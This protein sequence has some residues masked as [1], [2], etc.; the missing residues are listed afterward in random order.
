VEL[1]GIFKMADWQRLGAQAMQQTSPTAGPAA[2]AQRAHASGAAVPL[3][4][5][6]LLESAQ[7]ASVAEYFRVFN[8]GDAARMRQFYERSVVPNPERTIEQRMDTYE[9]LKTEVGPLK[10]L[11]ADVAEDGRVAVRAETL[12]GTPATVVFAIEPQAP[13]R[14]TTI[15]FQIG[16]GG[17]HR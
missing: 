2:D 13:Y 15:S 11:S 10:I 9:R 6:K 1:V 3:V 7:R 17:A 12:S 4:M 5:P 8:S 16:G 14:L